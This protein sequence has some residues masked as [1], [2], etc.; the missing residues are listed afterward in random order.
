[1]ARWTEEMRE[2]QRKLIQ[3]WKPWEK[4]RKGSPAFGRPQAPVVRHRN[5]EYEAL[6]EAL[7]HMLTTAGL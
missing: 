7:A 5:V 3:R 1:M 2:R 6:T 4:T